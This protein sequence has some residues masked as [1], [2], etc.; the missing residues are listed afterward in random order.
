MTDAPTARG[1]RFVFTCLGVGFIAGLMSGLFGVGGGTVVVPLLVLVLGYGQRL[2]A[3]TSLAAIVP[4]AAVGVIAYAVNDSV[5]WIPA[6]ILAAGAVVGAQ[7]GT[8]LLPRTPVT[9]LRWGFVGFLVIVIVS[10][11]LVIP[12]RD[13]GLPLT[14]VTVLG[15]IAL[16]VVTGIL[17]GLLGVGGGVIVVPVLLLLF[18]TSD[19]LAKGTSLL[20]MIPTAISGT[21]GNLIRKNVDLPAA[22]IVGV[23]A[24]ATAPVGTW[25]ATVVDPQLGNI[26]FAAFLTIIAV[27]M[28]VRAIRG[29]KTAR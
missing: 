8:W 23:A 19:L 4:T 3:G 7:I 26:L 13:A 29:R 6:L 27:Q 14:V 9:V 18:G 11:F 12:S 10:L 25:L 24:C 2:A 16:G 15:L 21:V 17:A 5:A 22:A 20:M 1:A 28:A